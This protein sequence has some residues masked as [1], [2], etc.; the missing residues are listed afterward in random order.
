MYMGHVSKVERTNTRFRKISN[1]QPDILPYNGGASTAAHHTNRKS[2]RAI[3]TESYTII[4]N[5]N[6]SEWRRASS[7]RYQRFVH[8]S[9]YG[10]Q[11]TVQRHSSLIDTLFMHFHGDSQ[12]AFWAISVA[13]HTNANERDERKITISIQI[14]NIQQRTDATAGTTRCE[15]GIYAGTA[16]AM[17]AQ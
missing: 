15:R 13:N 3:Q 1:W 9:T 11:C 14:S 2:I 16:K 17:A 10:A 12:Q 7:P 6:N 4:Q 5:H 8:L